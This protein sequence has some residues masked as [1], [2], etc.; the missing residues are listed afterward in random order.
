MSKNKNLRQIT[1]K[2]HEFVLE[3]IPN[4]VLTKY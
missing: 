2:I 1:T 4:A 3:L